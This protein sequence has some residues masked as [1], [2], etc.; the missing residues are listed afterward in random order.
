MLSVIF[1]LK[2]PALREPLLLFS[3]GIYINLQTGA[4]V[5]SLENELESA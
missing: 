1:S 2:D 5:E 4:K 3:E